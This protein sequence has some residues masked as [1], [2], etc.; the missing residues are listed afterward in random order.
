MPD[1]GPADKVLRQAEF[2]LQDPAPHTV[3]WFCSYG[4][5]NNWKPQQENKRKKTAGP[6]GHK[7][8][9]ALSSFA[10][11]PWGSDSFLHSI[12]KSVGSHSVSSLTWSTVYSEFRISV[13][14]KLLH[15]GTA[16]LH[17]QFW[18]THTILHFVMPLGMTATSELPLHLYR[19]LINHIRLHLN[20]EPIY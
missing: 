4:L 2:L 6:G 10:F 1:S 18:E 9:L 12:S 20:I 15:K 7:V 5:Q 14:Q 19:N 8:K 11:S 17:Q 13:S 3:H 16:P